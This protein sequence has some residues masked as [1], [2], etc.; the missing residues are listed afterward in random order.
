VATVHRYIKNQ[1]EHHCHRDYREEILT[2]L[3]RSGVKID[4]RYF[5]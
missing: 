1:E 5:D 4:E 3:R 2:L